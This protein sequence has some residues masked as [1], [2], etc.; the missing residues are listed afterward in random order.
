MTNLEKEKPVIKPIL[1]DAKAT[2]QK[3]LA[4]TA[5]GTFNEEQITALANHQAQN[6][7]KLIVERERVKTQIYQ[8]LTP[9]QRAKLEQMKEHFEKRIKER[10]M[11]GF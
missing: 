8:V 6:M 9:E 5:N 3:I 2:R 1:E 7:A 11:Q 10:V 4:A